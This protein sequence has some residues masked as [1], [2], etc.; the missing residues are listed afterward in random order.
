M[1]SIR[2]AF[3]LREGDR[4]PGARP[5]NEWKQVIKTRVT[6]VLGRDPTDVRMVCCDDQRNWM[7]YIGLPGESSKPVAYNSPQNDDIRLPPHIAKLYGEIIDALRVAVMNPATMTRRATPSR[8]IPLH[9]QS[10]WRSTNVQSRRKQPEIRILHVLESSSDAR[11]S[12]IAVT[13]LGYARPVRS[14]DRRLAESQPR[15]RR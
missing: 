12:A 10:N 15:P 4:F 1:S 5:I 13:A 8:K 3:S 7:I 2:A 6:Q 11:H 14:A 9:A